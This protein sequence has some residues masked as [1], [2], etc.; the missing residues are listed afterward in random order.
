M[1]SIDPGIRGVGAALWEDGELIAAEYVR[2]LAKLGGGPGECR[3]MARSVLLWT[4]RQYEDGKSL[5]R[6]VLEWPRTYAGR[7][8]QGDTNDL[9]PLAAV[10]GALAVTFFN[11]EITHYEP[12]FWKGSIGKPEP[13]QEYSI[14]TR[15]LSRLTP[16]EEVR[17]VWPK[18]KKLT[19]D[20]AD[21]IGVGLKFLDRFEKRRAFHRD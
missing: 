3:E 19:Y 11:A 12:H 9:F 14:T 6:L 20:V 2:N 1:L 17:V 16:E 5:Q 4:F 15:V 21:A 13:G 8:S 10:D 7:A 18:A